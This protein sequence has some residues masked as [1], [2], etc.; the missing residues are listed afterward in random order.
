MIIKAFAQYL[1]TADQNESASGVLARWLWEH[2]TC[3]PVNMVDKVL[4]CEIKMKVAQATNSK[5]LS[6]SAGSHG[7]TYVFEGISVSGKQL[8]HS[9]YEYSQSY[10]QQKW[11][12][13]IHKLKA[14]DFR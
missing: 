3:P 5:N 11:S 6:F 12:R 13:W 2:L 8:L 4:Q 7:P 10:E 1:H 9:L 14:S